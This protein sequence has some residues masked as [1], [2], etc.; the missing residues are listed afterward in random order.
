MIIELVVMV[1]RTLAKLVW[2]QGCH[3][4]Q[5]WLVMS[6]LMI[7]EAFVHG[8]IH[9]VV[10]GVVSAASLQLLFGHI[11][12]GDIVL[13]AIVVGSICAPTRIF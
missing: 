10:D 13:A 4:A 9:L 1:E 2:T 11:I 3:I 5:H 8:R 12:F 6:I 7:V